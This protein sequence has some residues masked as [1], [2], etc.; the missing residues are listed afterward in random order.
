MRVS[1]H[2][3]YDSAL[4]EIEHYLETEKLVEGQRAGAIRAIG[5]DS[6]RACTRLARLVIK[7]N[8]RSIRLSHRA[9]LG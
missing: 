9:L 2:G 4:A 8:Q 7:A 1:L 6:F 5:R 3:C